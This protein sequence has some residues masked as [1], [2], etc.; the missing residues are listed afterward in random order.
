MTDGER[1]EVI[2]R[3]EEALGFEI[4]GYDV[5]DE[6]L[7]A[8]ATDPDQF[9]AAVEQLGRQPPPV[10]PPSMLIS[11]LDDVLMPLSTPSQ[12]L[13]NPWLAICEGVN[14]FRL[15]FGTWPRF[16]IV[17]PNAYRKME[18]SNLKFRD[19]RDRIQDD[20]YDPNDPIDSPLPIY[21]SETLNEAVP[22]ALKPKIPEIPPDLAEEGPDGARQED[23]QE[24]ARPAGAR[25]A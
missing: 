18:G 23:A 24:G 1:R 2:G 14:R 22:F 7:A 9:E 10:L 21:T 11:M 12:F 16:L 25:Q 8:I 19:Y 5:T 3:L 6:I 17:H 15:R 4:D 20:P 13:T